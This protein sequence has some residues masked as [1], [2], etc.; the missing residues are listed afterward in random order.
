MELC[1][2][3]GWLDNR[4]YENVV[5]WTW[6]KDG[7]RYLIVVNLTESPAQALIN[8]GCDDL[9]GNRWRLT[10]LLSGATYEREGDGML[11]PGLYVDLRAWSYHFLQ[12]YRNT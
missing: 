4:S 8:V 1:E 11:S 7:D 5:A 9:R 12:L 6:N 10:D 2:R 3:I